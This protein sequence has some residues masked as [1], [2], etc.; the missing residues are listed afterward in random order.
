MYCGDA[1]TEAS[2]KGRSSVLL[3]ILPLTG[4]AQRVRMPADGRKSE[5][6]CV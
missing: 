1:G 6:A 2:V 4:G 5:A 3:D